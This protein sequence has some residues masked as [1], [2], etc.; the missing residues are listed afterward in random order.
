LHGGRRP[1]GEYCLLTAAQHCALA[2]SDQKRHVTALIA[3]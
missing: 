3:L 2:V 1:A